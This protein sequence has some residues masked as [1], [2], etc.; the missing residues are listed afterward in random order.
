MATTADAELI[1]KLYDIRREEVVRKSRNFVLFE[2]S[3]K[4]VEELLAV[5]RGAGTEENAQW[6]QVVTYWEMAASF[7]LRGAVDADLYLDSQGEGV[8]LYTKFYELYKTATGVDFMPQTAAMIQQYPGAQR[9]HESV[10][11]LFAKMAADA[12]VKADQSFNKG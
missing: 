11:K 4:T 2:F 7:V 3:P 9:I 5:Q 8:F 6:R 10:K 1:L 12:A